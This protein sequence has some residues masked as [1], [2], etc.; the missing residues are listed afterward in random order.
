MFCQLSRV[1]AWLVFV[2]GVARVALG[3]WMTTLA[4]AERDVVLGRYTTEATTGAVIDSGLL[5]IG[6]ALVLG[7]LAE[8][9]LAVRKQ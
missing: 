1:V 5:V 7:T 8:I 6:L 4:P 9:G 2:F 3:F